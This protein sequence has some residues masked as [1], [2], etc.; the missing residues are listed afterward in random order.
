VDLARP[1]G[2]E[3][4]RI[5]PALRE[6]GSELGQRTLRSAPVGLPPVDQEADAHS[7]EGTLSG[8]RI[9][10][11]V[12]PLHRP[13]PRGVVRVT[14]GLVEALE[15]RGRVEVVRLAPPERRNLRAWRASDL[16]RLARELGLDGIHSPVSAFAWRGPGAR[17]QTIHELPWRHGAREG[18]DLRHRAWAAFGPLRADAVVTATEFVARDLRRRLLPGASKL[19]VVPWGVDARFTDDPPASVVDEVV[20]GRYRIPQ[21]PW[22]IALGAVRPKKDLAA[23][24][25]GLAEHLRRGAKPIRLVVTGG[26]TP[27]LRRDL[28]L[29]NRLGLARHVTTLDEIAEEDLPSVLRLAS[30]VPVLSRSEG[31]GLPVLEAMACGTP[32]IVPEDS[33]QAEVAGSACIPVDPD[34]PASVADGLALALAERETR[35]G[36][37]A[38]R[39]RELSWDRCAERVEAIWSEIA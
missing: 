16:P 19:R 27:Q 6:S 23:V 32:V 29:A 30:V 12:S 24:V 17:V 36:A 25:N 3:H 5:V 4:A 34:D 28:G 14:R 15:R 13:H 21:G 18:A 26:D 22:A 37:L 20:L 9:G 39:G 1:L 2:G 11:D 10:F 31:F 38:A 8:V 35:R 33:A 7:A